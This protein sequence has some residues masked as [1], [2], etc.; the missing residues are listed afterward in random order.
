MC[1]LLKAL[2]LTY[3]VYLVQEATKKDA[4]SLPHLTYIT[5]DQIWCNCYGHSA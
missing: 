5:D 3:N 4:T 1:W 2:A